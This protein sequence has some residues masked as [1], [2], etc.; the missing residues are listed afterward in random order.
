MGRINKNAIE[1]TLP[2]VECARA[3]NPLMVLYESPIWWWGGREVPGGGEC[4]ISEYCNGRRQ[5]KYAG[6]KANRAE[7]G[8]NRSVLIKLW[9]FFCF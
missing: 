6:L 4:Q 9:V 1:T 8:I 7:F 5:R 3:K 2:Y